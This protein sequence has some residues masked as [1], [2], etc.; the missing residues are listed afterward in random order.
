MPSTRILAAI[1]LGACL[2]LV[3]LLYHGYVIP[4]AIAKFIASTAFIAL[5]L[6]AGALESPFGKFILAWLF[7]GAATCC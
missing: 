4:A 1:S 3:T 6:R 7:P 2:A 5:A